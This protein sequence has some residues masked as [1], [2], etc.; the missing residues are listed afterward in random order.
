LGHE[1]VAGGMKA[2]LVFTAFHALGTEGVI[3]E[4]FGKMKADHPGGE[5]GATIR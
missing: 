3:G 4:A 2:E 1:L 5:L